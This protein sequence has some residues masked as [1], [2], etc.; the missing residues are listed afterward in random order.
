[1]ALEFDVGEYSVAVV[2][3]KSTVRRHPSEVLGILPRT[4][5]TNLVYDVNSGAV[6]ARILVSAAKRESSRGEYEGFG[7]DRRQHTI[8]NTE[9]DVA[10]LVKGNMPCLPDALKFANQLGVQVDETKAAT[11]KRDIVNFLGGGAN[12]KEAVEGALFP[13]RESKPRRGDL[14]NWGYSDGRWRF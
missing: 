8:R 14:S 12:I 5:S 11:Y 7:F 9:R 6:Q 1:M 4:A 3:G 2:V 13:Q 10:I